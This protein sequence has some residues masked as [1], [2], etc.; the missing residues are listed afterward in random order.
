MYIITVI[1]LILLAVCLYFNYKDKQKILTLEEII[2]EYARLLDIANDE[3]IRARAPKPFQMIPMSSVTWQPTEGCNCPSCT[4][5]FR[6]DKTIEK[7]LGAPTGV[8]ACDEYLDISQEIEDVI[9]S[10]DGKVVV[11]WRKNE[12]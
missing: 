6:K 10:S 11:K 8:Y 3:A 9:F 12:S 4:E 2:K 1:S 5:Y 7:I